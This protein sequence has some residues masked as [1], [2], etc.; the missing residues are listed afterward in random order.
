MKILFCCETMRSGGA[1]K[2]IATL[3]NRFSLLGHEV[4]I[5]M[6]SENES[7]SFYKLESNVK[8]VSLY[9]VMKNEKRTII[10]KV[11]KLRSVVDY[12]SPDVV[13]SFLKHI[14]IYTFFALK[15]TNYPV[16]YSERNDPNSY[17]L[18]YKIAL[19]HIFKQSN[20]CVFQTSDAQLW[21]GKEV[22]KKSIVLPNPVE[23]SASFERKKIKE[24]RI[25]AV[26]RL[27]D[28]KNYPLLIKAFQIFSNN[29][30]DYK[31]VIYGNGKKKNAITSLINKYNLQDCVELVGISN[32]WHSEELN[33]S[34]YVL[35]SKYEGMPNAL[36]EALC[37][38]IP[39]VSVDC[40]IGG[41][42][43]LS[44]IFNDRL[45]LCKNEPNDMAKKIEEAVKTEL[46]KPKVNDC[47][48]ADYIANKWITFLSEIISKK[49][50]K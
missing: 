25:F 42:R 38:G 47:L 9:Q 32:N 23:I 11:K 21:Y 6:V 2:V 30:R 22:I 37:L 49:G 5:I 20:G 50:K 10:N 48:S 8:L 43:Y 19:K 18:F 24:K 41:P 16:V 17:S 33:S 39:C 1:E 34:A 27:E 29:H 40:S 4:V 15:N 7:N 14:I 46:K 28:Q 13:I 26:G 31:L 3:S 12:F 44:T 36:A 35:S 45:F